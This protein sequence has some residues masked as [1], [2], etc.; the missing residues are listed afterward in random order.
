MLAQIKGNFT[1]P[2]VHIAFNSFLLTLLKAPEG[3]FLLYQNVLNDLAF[4]TFYQTYGVN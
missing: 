3:V 4:Y 1:T 2:T